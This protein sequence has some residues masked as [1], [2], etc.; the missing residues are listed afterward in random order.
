[1][2]DVMDWVKLNKQLLLEYWNDD[3]Y[4]TSKMIKNIRKV[5]TVG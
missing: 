2:S 1:M 4:P 5:E 3:V